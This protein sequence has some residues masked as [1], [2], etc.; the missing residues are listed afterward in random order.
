MRHLNVPV[1]NAHP[2][3]V[4]PVEPVEPSA[5]QSSSKSNNC[6]QNDCEMPRLVRR[7]VRTVSLSGLNESSLELR[8][9]QLPSTSAQS[10]SNQSTMVQTTMANPL[11]QGESH[12]ESEED[13]LVI[14]ESIDPDDNM[15]SLPPGEN[16][17]DES[18][19][20][21]KPSSSAD[22]DVSEQ[23]AIAPVDSSE[24]EDNGMTTRSHYKPRSVKNRAGMS[25][26][27]VFLFYYDH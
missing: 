12:S 22:S 3:A 23:S 11:L 25:F 16:P 6:T 2:S 21:A 19:D 13:K 5:N 4:E 20:V 18:V 17:V 7:V 15:Q 8:L 14:D 9:R 1:A 26:G 24:E 10:T 27:N